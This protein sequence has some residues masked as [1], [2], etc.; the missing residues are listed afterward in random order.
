M[1]NQTIRNLLDKKKSHN[2]YQL[3]L[4]YE[5]YIRQRKLATNQKTVV[6]HKG[7][8]L[9]FTQKQ[10]EVLSLVARGFSNSKIA[11]I[12]FAKESTT[13]LLIYRLMCYLEDNLYENIDRFYL[14]IIAQQIEMELRSTYTLNL[15]NEIKTF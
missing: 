15:T 5:N 9:S 11:K 6:N 8:K 1:Q 13:K 3:F 10:I 12:T 4:D 14:I 7:F 2:S